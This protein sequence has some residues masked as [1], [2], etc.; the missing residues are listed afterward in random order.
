[1]SGFSVDAAESW[2]WDCARRTEMICGELKATP[3]ASEA[4]QKFF[5]VN[6]SL[7]LDAMALVELQQRRGQSSQSPAPGTRC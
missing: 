7:L 2:A 5:R 6:I 3:S 1:M 4:P